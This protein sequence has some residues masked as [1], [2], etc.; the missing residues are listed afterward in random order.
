MVR[1]PTSPRPATPRRVTP[2]S[3]SPG[4]TVRPVAQPAADRPPSSASPAKTPGAA[5]PA[6]QTGSPAR[7]VD[8]SSRFRRAFRSRPW[9]RRRRQIAIGIISGVLILVGALAALLWLPALRL[10]HVTV[11]GLGYVQ[12]E[13]VSRIAR[14][15]LDESLL[16]VPTDALAE[17]VERVPGVAGASVHRSFPDSVTITVTERQPLAAITRADGSAAV[18]DPTGVELPAAAGEGVALVPLTVDGGSADPHGAEESMIQVLAALPADLRSAV[19]G[20]QASSRGDVTLEVSLETA[21]ETTDGH[22]TPATK[23]VVWG[24]AADAELKAE[25]LQALLTQPG[26]VIDVSSPVAPVTR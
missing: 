1:R 16:L 19:T 24:D 26:S 5:A 18:L 2:G 17:S 23:T 25:V 20:V 3:V 11:E 15:H 22:G 4:A 13:E 9:L 12:E 6:P 21:A 10:Q 8:A 14:A 7:V